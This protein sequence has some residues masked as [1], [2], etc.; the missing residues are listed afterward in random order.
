MPS[1]IACA[2]ARTDPYGRR[3]VSRKTQEMIMTDDKAETASNTNGAATKEN[4]TI[5][6]GEVGIPAPAGT[7]T[8]RPWTAD[9]L[10]PSIR[11][12]EPSSPKIGPS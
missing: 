5:E 6:R 8:V 2:G 3:K 4:Q 1:P 12:R 7:S 9:F 11:F 10:L